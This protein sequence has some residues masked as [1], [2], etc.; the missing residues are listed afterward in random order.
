MTAAGAV[1]RYGGAKQQRITM[2][3]ASDVD[4]LDP[5]RTDYTNGSP[6]AGL[7]VTRRR[8]F[9]PPHDA[10]QAPAYGTEGQLRAP[11]TAWPRVVRAS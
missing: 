8:G 4:Y 3:A 5:G 10:A 1:V 9:E 7:S 11:A 2:L 6:A